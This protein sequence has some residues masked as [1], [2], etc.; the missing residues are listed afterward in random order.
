MALPGGKILRLHGRAGPVERWT[1]WRWERQNLRREAEQRAV[2]EQIAAWLVELIGDR[3]S[4]V[5]TRLDPRSA[6]VD[7]DLIVDGHAMTLDFSGITQ[8]PEHDWSGSLRTDVLEALADHS[9][10]CGFNVSGYAEEIWL[11]QHGPW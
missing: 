11:D 4:V 2:V 8:W 1:S 7:I 10:G 9:D 6:H 3:G 5:A